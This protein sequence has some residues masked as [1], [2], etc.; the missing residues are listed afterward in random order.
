MGVTE[1]R[2]DRTPILTTLTL[3]RRVPRDCLNHVLRMVNT[4]FS[5]ARERNTECEISKK[6]ADLE[7]IYNIRK[8]YLLPVL[9]DNAISVSR[10]Y[11]HK[12]FICVR[13]KI[14]ITTKTR[15][16]ENM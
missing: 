6:C 10:L 7:F 8:I 9:D 4:F 1:H 11:R 12:S 5:R 16:Y 14:Y 13:N 15:I 3:D 2:A